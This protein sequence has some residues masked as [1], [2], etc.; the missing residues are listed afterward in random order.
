MEKFLNGA[1][2]YLKLSIR[3]DRPEELGIEL[4]QQEGSATMERCAI[5]ATM[6]NYA[7][8]R[9]I[10]LK[11]DTINAT[12]LYADYDDVHFVEKESYPYTKFAKD[13]NGDYIVV[14]ETN[15]SFAELSSWPEAPAYRNRSG[16]RYRPGYKLTQ[17]WKK[18][19]ADVDP[20]L[21]LRVN[22]RAYYWSMASKDKSHYIK[23]PGGA[24]FENFELR[25][26]FKPGQKF[27]YGLTRKTAA[28][29]LR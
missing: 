8:L 19:A 25:E 21:R 1:H 27:Y 15:E 23:I 4:F 29:L 7:R 2:P 12:K 14:A 26:N 10:Y 3:S 11:D 9:T 20:S 5:T 22:G 6:G 18:E 17:Y 13:S 24:A 28:A 16:W